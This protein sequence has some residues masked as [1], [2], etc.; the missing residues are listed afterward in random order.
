MDES[1]WLTSRTFPSMDWLS[2]RAQRPEARAGRRRSRDHFPRADRAGTFAA[3]ITGSRIT[4]D[5]GVL[6][7]GCLDR[8]RPLHSRR[9]DAVPI[10]SAS[11]AEDATDP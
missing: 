7:W 1:P 4:G 10:D 2:G 3:I 5:A 11:P 6:G 8:R 9:G